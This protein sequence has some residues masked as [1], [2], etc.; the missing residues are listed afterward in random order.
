MS[1]NLSSSIDSELIIL[2]TISYVPPISMVSVLGSLFHPCGLDL[3]FINLPATRTRR[4]ANASNIAPLILGVTSVYAWFGTGALSPPHRNVVDHFSPPYMDCFAAPEIWTTI[5]HHTL[6]DPMMDSRLHATARAN[7]NSV[8]RGYRTL[9]RY[10]S[11]FWSRINL[12]SRVY[13]SALE[14]IVSRLSVGCGIEIQFSMGHLTAQEILSPPA[15][16][17]LRLDALMAVINP[18]SPRWTSFSLSTPHSA[19]FRH[20]HSAC[21]G[22][23]VPDLQ[24]LTLEYSAQPGDDVI[25]TFDT[26]LD[27]PSNDPSLSPSAWFPTA[28]GLQRVRS[29]SV[30]LHWLTLASA[31]YLVDV[32]LSDISCHLDWGALKSLLSSSFQLSTLRLRNLPSFPIPL[33]GML[34]SRS[35]TLLSLHFP[36]YADSLHMRTFSQRLLLPFLTDLNLQCDIWEDAIF[37]LGYC[38]L[39]ASARRLS[40][41]GVWRDRDALTY[42]LPHMVRVTDLDISAAPGA[43]GALR[44]WSLAQS[45]MSPRLPIL[46]ID[47]PSVR[48]LLLNLHS[49][50]HIKITGG[51][52]RCC[53]WCQIAF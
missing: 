50:G 22:L 6:P 27:T 39:I 30:P 51:W 29:E 43:F 18:L 37:L 2:P 26:S 46:P 32:D 4:P 23:F 28:G 45:M 41:R 21:S 38:V 14:F 48:P 35:I 5:F 40:I 13:V 12:D 20:I 15:R 7:L 53:L 34:T 47:H 17:Y 11:S 1:T 3:T 9:L 24:S 49:T 33:V 31:G 10:D 44:D 36:I 19:I 42:L 25:Y 52:Q 8:C 16:L